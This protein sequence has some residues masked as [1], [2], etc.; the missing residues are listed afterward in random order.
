M[1]DNMY[2]SNQSDL[3]ICN[4]RGVKEKERKEKCKLQLRPCLVSTKN[5]K[6]FKISH[7]I[8]FYGTCMGY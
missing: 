3:H 4:A 8:K 2:V 6:L 1:I 5:Q 7:H